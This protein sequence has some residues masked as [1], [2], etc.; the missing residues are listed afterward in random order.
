M[1]DVPATTP[2]SSSDATLAA[3][4][5]MGATVGAGMAW[6]VGVTVFNKL[7]TFIAQI[8][9]GWKLTPNDYDVYATATAV[10]GI[11]FICREAGMRE[12]LA[13]LSRTAHDDVFGSAFWLA[14][15]YN[16]IMAGVVCALALPLAQRLGGGSYAP[17]LWLVAA[18]IVLGTAGELL[19]NKLRVELRFKDYGTNLAWL[20]FIRQSAVVG[21]A[22][23]GFGAL[24]LGWAAVVSAVV[25]GVM[26]IAATKDNV[27]A[28]K[29]EPARWPMLMKDSRWFMLGAMAS[30]VLDWGPFAIL[31]PLLTI[32]ATVSGLFAFAFT[33]TAQI[34]VL[35]SWT[36]TIVLVPALAR[37][38]HDKE[39]L[40][41][42][43][44][45]ALSAIMLVATGVSMGLGVVITPLEELLWHGKWKESVGAIMVLG[46]LYPFRVTYGLTAAMLMAEGRAKA[47]AMVTLFEGL[48]LT[49]ACA[50]GALVKEDATTIAIF[51]GL[52]L[53]VSRVGVMIWKFSSLGVPALRGVR[54]A[55]TVMQTTMKPWIIGLVATLLAEIVRRASTPG[56]WLTGGSSDTWLQHA[57][58]H[59]PEK[60]RHTAEHGALVLITG[61]VFSLVFVV[62]ARV[63]MPDTLRDLAG[64]MPARLRPVVR[65]VLFLPA[66]PSHEAGHG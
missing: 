51:A 14:F 28:R 9:L 37:F 30:N 52:W 54:G 59:L 57:V 1:K 36:V 34:G 2:A 41:Q 44:L 21:F 6:M 17:M 63:A 42:A 39:R 25:Q 60:L 5:S 61:A 8:V 16:I 24:A 27:F 46:L 10:A 38:A 18:S 56:A 12:V 47:Y 7:L 20:N 65:R 64:S 31:R 53:L 40:A 43:A 15:S 13:R 50:V 62:L 32:S 49:I 26:G 19:F 58:A 29:A 55:L 22:V 11:V 4:A 66:A 3:E 23:G 33:I 48:G 35:L 45:R